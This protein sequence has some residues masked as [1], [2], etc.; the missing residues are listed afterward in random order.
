MMRALKTSSSLSQPLLIFPAWHFS[1][2]RLKQETCKKAQPSIAAPVAKP[3]AKAE[4]GL[5]PASRDKAVVA[6]TRQR[7]ARGHLS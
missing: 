5:S 2:F 4:L 3:E 6:L 7:D 1:P